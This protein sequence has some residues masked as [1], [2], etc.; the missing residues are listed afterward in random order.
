VLAAAGAG[1]DDVV[2]TTTFLIDLAHR[3]PVGEARREVFDDPPPAN[4]L[5]VVSSLAD[6]DYLVEIE[7]IATLS[8]DR[9]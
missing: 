9:A 4:S 3:G 2:K 5:L 8:A 1:F 6:P 7:A